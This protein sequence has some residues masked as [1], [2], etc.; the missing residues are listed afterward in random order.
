MVNAG[1]R[2]I[3]KIVFWAHLSAGLVAGVVIAILSFTGAALAFEKDLLTWA[4]RDARRV[5]P[6]AAGA[7][8]LSVEELVTRVVAP[9]PDIRIA[10][11]VVSIDPHDA[12]VFG[13]PN[14]TSLCVNPYTGE[15]REPLAPRMRGFLQTMRAWHVR[16]NFKPGPGNGGAVLVSA[17]NFVFVLLAI[18][19]LVLWWP[20]VWQW[21]ALRPAVWFVRAQGRARDWNWHNVIGVWSLPLIL[22]LAG[23]GIVL[24]YRWAN[25]LVFQLAGE[26]PPTTQAPSPA[27][28]LVLTPR[29][30]GQVP[31]TNDAL[32]AAAQRAYPH[33]AQLT[34]RFNPPRAA[35]ASGNPPPPRT[36]S[37]V[38]K[39]ENPW[40][41]FNLRTVTLDAFNGAVVRADDYS[42]LSAGM[43]AR[44]WIRLLHSGEALGPVVQ[45]LSALACLGGCVLVYTGFALAWRRFFPG[46]T[47]ASRA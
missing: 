43:R 8:R 6:P 16:L 33:W 34:L 28:P 29:A 13:L 20:R 14:N 4:E 19:G 36:R 30:P 21:R 22:V 17:A 5:E 9:R 7:A 44:R 23:T 26:T 3:R 15:I 2:M 1:R 37:I 24:S 32:L 42:T 31:L 38:V 45:L 12:V 35:T 11:V 25:E 47:R 40:P 18:S 10:N 46:G 41:R 39:D 27:A